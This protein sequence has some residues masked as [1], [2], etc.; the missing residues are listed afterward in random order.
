MIPH[1]ISHKELFPK[2][3]DHFPE[4]AILTSASKKSETPYKGP[5]GP[6]TRCSRVELCGRHLFRGEFAPKPGQTLKK[7]L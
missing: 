2:F 5:G 1:L 4:I 7:H 3:A 6:V